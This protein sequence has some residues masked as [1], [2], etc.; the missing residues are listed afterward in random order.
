MDPTTLIGMLAAVGA[1]LAMMLMEGTDP[2][3]VVL[4]PALILVV[5]GTFGAAIAG[6]TSADVRRIGSWVRLAFPPDRGPRTADLIALLVELAAKARREGML[7]LEKQVSTVGDPFL[8]RGLQMAIDG[9]PMEQLRSV[10]EGEIGVLRNEDRVAARFFTRM[11]G[12]AL[13]IGIIGTV[14]GLVHV[15]QSLDQPEKLGPL[16]AGAFVA[17]LWGVLSANFFWLPL[18]AKIT[19]TSDLR[20]AQ[21]ELLLEGVAEIL[22]GSSP[23]A[24]RQRLRSM[25]PPSE[26]QHAA[27]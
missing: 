26:A 8:R 7:P 11:G 23:R 21:M 14:I 13:T 10:L 19:R 24:I 6:S 20:T 1:L 3:A 2:V 18:A 27:A 15:L 22:A 25:L 16:V 9:V 17:T 12:Y 5:G 4:L